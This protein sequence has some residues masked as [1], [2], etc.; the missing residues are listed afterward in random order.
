MQNPLHASHQLP[1]LSVTAARQLGLTCG[2]VQQLYT[3]VFYSVQLTY[4]TDEPSFSIH[5]IIPSCCITGCTCRLKDK[6]QAQLHNG[7]ATLPHCLCRLPMYYPSC[8]RCINSYVLQWPEH[9][10]HATFNRNADQ[11]QQD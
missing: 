8:G 4:H 11:G 6:C 3:A 7:T 10:L 9:G 5:T 1:S 2:A